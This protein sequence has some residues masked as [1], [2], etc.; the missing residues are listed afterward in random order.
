[1][2]RYV[3]QPECFL[4]MFVCVCTDVGLSDDLPVC[5]SGCLVV[6]VC[7]VVCP[8]IVMLISAC[9]CVMNV[10]LCVRLGAYLYVS[11]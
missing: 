6:C 2:R 4:D 5:L 9:M 8:S 1:M 11:A 10:R 3:S 7:R